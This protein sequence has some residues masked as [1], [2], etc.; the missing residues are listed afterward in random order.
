MSDVG[1]RHM[2][3]A[4]PVL[5]VGAAVLSRVDGRDC[6]VLIE[7]GHPPRQGTWSLPG[8]RVELGEALEAALV[9]ELREETG[10]EVD[11]GPLVEVVEVREPDHHFVI[12]DYVATLRCQ[13]SVLR[14]GDDAADARWVPI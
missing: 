11:V 6:V 8:G 10:L 3:K 13:A 9:R 12:L 1:C 5:G 7:R 14:A 4:R 2:G